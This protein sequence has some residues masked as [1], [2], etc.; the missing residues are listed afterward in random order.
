LTSNDDLL[1]LNQLEAGRSV[2]RRNGH[3]RADDADYV[4]A[5]RAAEPDAVRAIN[6]PERFVAALVAQPSA[7][8]D[9][10]W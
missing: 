2:L 4:D 10:R 6:D 1:L 5:H 7:G 3:L 8:R 9:A